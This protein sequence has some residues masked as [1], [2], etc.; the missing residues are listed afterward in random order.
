MARRGV[1]PRLFCFGLGYSAQALGR[2]LLA[3]GWQVA[4]TTR[5][6]EQRAALA[7]AGFQVHLFARGRPLDPGVLADATHLLASIPPDETGDPVL[8]LHRDHLLDLPGLAWAGYL[9]TTGVYGDRDGAWVDEAEPVAPTMARTRRR[10][11][12]EGAWLAS[13]LPVHRFRLAGIYGPAP[14]RNPLDAVRRGTARRIVKPGQVFGRIHVD[15]IVQVLRASMARPNPGAIY[16]LADDLPAPPQDV[17]AHAAELLGVPPPPEVPF[18]DA[19][20]SPMAQSFYGDNRRIANARI[21]EEL[22]VRL[23][24][25][26]Y[27]DGLRAILEGE[28][29]GEASPGASTR[30]EVNEARKLG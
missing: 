10:V 18:A 26:T 20:L 24:H 22:G 6:E 23:L 1:S 9:G 30:L 14:G 21:K 3:E 29:A 19:D 4:G 11:A 28:K 12:A 17:V 15:D 16:N 2:A 25:P 5:S 27:R 8:A 7:E 13:G